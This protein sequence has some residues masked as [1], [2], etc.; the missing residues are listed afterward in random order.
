MNPERNNWK[1][2]DIEGFPWT[3]TIIKKRGS[4][5]YK[6]Y[7]NSRFVCI[8]EADAEHRGIL[9]KVLGKTSPRDI[10]MVGGEPFCKDERDDLFDGKVYSSFRF[11]T[12]QDLTEVLAIIRENPS[13]MSVFEEASMQ[14][15]TESTFWVREPAHKLLCR[16]KPQF[17]DAST[18]NLSVSSDDTAHYRLTMLYFQ[19]GKLFVK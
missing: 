7:Y 18:D 4:T 11:P 10:M 8:R 17:Y 12:L 9:V 5:T 13:L 14:F 19:N 1:V 16:K 2:G 15:N 6:H 3:S